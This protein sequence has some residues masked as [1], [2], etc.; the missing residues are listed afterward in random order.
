LI[1]TALVAG[2][3][4]VGGQ[5]AAE[6]DTRP[7]LTVVAFTGEGVPPGSGDAMADE[8]ATHFVE[9]GRYRVMPRDWLPSSAA[10]AQPALAALRETAAA[11]GVEYLVLGEARRGR[12][13][14]TPR[15]DLVL[16][17]VRI[18]SVATG[19][20]IRTAAGRIQT[21]MRSSR[22]LR[23]VP[24]TRARRPAGITGHLAAAAVIAAQAKGQSVI[25]PRKGWEQTLA[26]IARAITLPG[27]SR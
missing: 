26:D 18:V 13:L 9:T 3:V 16:I 12:S 4:S 1:V 23:T 5:P 11:A 2:L 25:P 21:L 6:R 20:T 17:D 14:G 8:L 22:R 10:K 15:P 24:M 19:D 7:T 27:G